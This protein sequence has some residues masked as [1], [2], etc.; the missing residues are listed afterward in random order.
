MTPLKDTS[1]PAYN[2][3]GYQAALAHRQSGADYRALI[4]Q[5]L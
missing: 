5:D 4:V 2:S 3:P 1:M